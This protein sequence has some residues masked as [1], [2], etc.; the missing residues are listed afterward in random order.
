MDLSL[1]HFVFR[2]QGLQHFINDQHN[3]GPHTDIVEFTKDKATH[4]KWT[5]PAIRPMGFPISKQCP[6]IACKRLKTR[7]PKIS[8]DQKHIDIVC[9]VCKY[10][11]TFM[12]PPGWS[13]VKGQLRHGDDRGAWI[14]QVEHLAATRPQNDDDVNMT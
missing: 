2:R 11:D 10:S 13:W 12:F 4:F 14:H 5:H 8:K 1:N 3:L 9:K 7:I 6:N